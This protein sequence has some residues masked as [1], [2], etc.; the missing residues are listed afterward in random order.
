MTPRGVRVAAEE[1]LAE[2]VAKGW[3]AVNQAPPSTAAEPFAEDVDGRELRSAVRV[4]TASPSGG[5]SGALEEENPASM[6][7]GELA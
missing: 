6:K 5:E 7:P 4:P 1:I 2:R 3:S